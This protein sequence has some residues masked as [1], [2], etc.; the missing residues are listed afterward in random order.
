L[1]GATFTILAGY[2]QAGSTEPT[3]LVVI[4][5]GRPAPRSIV[6]RARSTSGYAFTR[7]VR[8]NEEPRSLCR[9]LAEQG[10]SVF[11]VSLPSPAD[12]APVEIE[13]TG[14]GTRATRTLVPL[15]SRC[16]PEGLPFVFGSCLY[17]YLP[18]RSASLSAALGAERD[19]G[20]RLALFLGDNVYCDVHPTQ[21]GPDAFAHVARIYAHAFGDPAGSGAALSQLPTMVAFDDHD[22]YD[23]YPETQPHVAR[24]WLPHVR[25]RH[26]R[27][28]TEGI[29]LFQAPL[30]PTPIVSSGRSYTFDIEPLSFFVLDLR[31]SRSRLDDP[32]PRL[33]TDDEL[34]AFESWARGLSAPGVLA[35]EQPLF[36]EDGSFHEPSPAAFHRQFDRILRALRDAPFDVLLLAGDLHWSQ[37]V[38]LD[39]DGRR[40]HEVTSS[41]LVR[42]PSFS[43]NMLA[44]LLGTPDDQESQEVVI[45]K[46]VTRPPY[47]VPLDV[48]SYVMGTSVAN[49]FSRLTARV[50]GASRVRVDVDFF[51]HVARR[52]APCE[53]D[54][55]RGMAPSVAVGAPCRTSIELGPIRW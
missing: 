22:F 46:A 13:V 7:P 20:A 50:V 34:A 2:A 40:V 43:R 4:A 55:G 52:V 1:G 37:V 32:R 17:A 33:T 3:R 41:P 36:L 35:I 16:P 51:D 24:T 8:A 27:A 25:E 12:E 28:A 53:P 31:T 48:A 19:A 14:S 44:R 18:D 45:P 21:V 5:R 9:A 49:G 38:T 47:A 39:V 11:T 15:P 26:V 23:G 30:N 29:A 10:T 54:R 42:I 6:V